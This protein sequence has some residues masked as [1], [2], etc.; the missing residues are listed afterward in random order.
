MI[1]KAFKMKIY[2]DKKEVYIKRHRPIW[3]QLQIVLKVHG[4]SNY[5]LFL[6]DETHILFGCRNYS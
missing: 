6:D 5:S 3:E 1:R 2:A 4:V